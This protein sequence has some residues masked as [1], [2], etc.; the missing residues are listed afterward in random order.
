MGNRGGQ[1]S[2]LS[3]IRKVSC[4]FM[5][6]LRSDAISKASTARSNGRSRAVMIGLTLIR[7]S[8]I[9]RAG[10]RIFLMEA[11]HADDADFLADD[12][13]DPGSPPRR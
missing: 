11:E 5:C 9:S 1:W 10:Q 7:P 3:T 13:V 4:T 12:G 6:A 8:L 2:C